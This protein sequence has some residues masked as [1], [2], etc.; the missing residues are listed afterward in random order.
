M[1]SSKRLANAF[2]DIGLCYAT[3]GEQDGS[4]DRR[5]TR[6]YRPGAGQHCRKWVAK[7]RP[8]GPHAATA[9]DVQRIWWITWPYL[10]HSRG[11]DVGQRLCTPPQD[12]DS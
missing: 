11:C 4:A 12:V 1:E 7:P 10:P 9:R 8:G 6:W 3:H 5:E 2:H